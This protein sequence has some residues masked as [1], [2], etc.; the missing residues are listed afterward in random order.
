GLVTTA[1]GNLI[2]GRSIN[3]TVP[4]A[5]NRLFVY[6]VASGVVLRSRNVTGLASILSA[7]TDGSR[8]MAGPLLFDTQTLTIVGRTGNDLNATLG[9]GSAFCV[10]GNSVYASFN[11]AAACCAQTPINPLKPN[12]P[13]DP[14]TPGVVTPCGDGACPGGAFG[15][16]GV[17]PTPAQRQ[18]TVAVPL[19]LR[20]SSLTP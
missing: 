16:A 18:Q 14:A 15:A 11:N 1:S 7:S 4:G 13:Q 5:A 8:F 10:D 6:E 19:R 12:R 17:P 20:S 2:V 9:G 3:L